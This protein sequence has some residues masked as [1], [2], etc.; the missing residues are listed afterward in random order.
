MIYL[1]ATLLTLVNAFWLSLN[2]FRLPGNWLMLATTFLA[3][4]WQWQ[5]G[6]FSVWTLLAALLLATL[7]EV[8]ELLTGLAGARAAGSGKRGA[9]GALIGGVIGA[10]AGTFLIPIPVLGSLVGACGGACVGAWAMELSGGRDGRA[11]WRAG[12]GAGAGTLAGTILKL[13]VGAVIWLVLAVAAFV[14]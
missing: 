6:M 11:S 3:A 9:W 12:M 8:L 10:A 5:R 2:L 7:G 1:W 14:P 13:A 4:W